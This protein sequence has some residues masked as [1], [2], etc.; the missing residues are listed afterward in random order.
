MARIDQ[1]GAL[2]LVADPIDDSVVECI[3]V[4]DEIGVSVTKLLSVAIALNYY[5]YDH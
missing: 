4:T 1:V 2:H 3:P 5:K